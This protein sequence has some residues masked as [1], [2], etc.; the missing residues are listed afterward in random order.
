MKSIAGSFELEVVWEAQGF[1]QPEAVLAVPGHPWIYVSNPN[2]PDPGY[3]SRI[4]TSGK[5]DA[6]RWVEGVQRP[7][8]MV[9]TDNNLYV[10]D[11]TRVVQIDPVSA[12]VIQEFPS[13]D[14]TSLN[15]IDVNANGQFFIS[16][17][18]SNTIATIDNTA[19]TDW[20]TTEALMHPNAVLAQNDAL[21]VGGV[22]ADM[23]DL[24][25]GK[26]GSIVR[27]DYEQKTTQ[28]VAGSEN[29]ATWDGLVPFKEGFLGSSPATGEI[30]YVANGRNTLIATLS[31]GISDFGW[32]ADKQ[33]MYV[34][35]LPEGKVIAY[36]IIQR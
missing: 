8:G 2:E 29:L 27:I 31:P 24:G 12:E 19:T 6:Y 10:V 22:G 23:Q 20:T 28:T 36:K 7:T 13:A 17:V 3:I 4:S 25:P 21:Y 14:A 11:V 35:H 5:I 18:S 9:F 30:W 32:D 26:F 34:P 1:S 33:I 16:D 15:D